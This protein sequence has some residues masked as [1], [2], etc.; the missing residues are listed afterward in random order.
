M[1]ISIKPD[2]TAFKLNSR[3]RLDELLLAFAGGY[4]ILVLW[5]LANFADSGVT[6]FRVLSSKVNQNCCPD[7]TTETGDDPDSCR[8]SRSEEVVIAVSHLSSSKD[9]GIGI[10]TDQI[11]CEAKTRRGNVSVDISWKRRWHLLQSPHH[12][13]KECLPRWI[14]D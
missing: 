7:T 2:H 14:T 13:T 6:H 1:A 5:Y 10:L 3:P 8:P 4:D 9:Q 11:D 12:T